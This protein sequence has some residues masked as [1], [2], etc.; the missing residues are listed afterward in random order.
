MADFSPQPVLAL[1]A[2]I[3][4]VLFPRLRYL[5]ALYLIVIGVR[6]LGGV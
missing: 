5:I 6:G 3:L 1:G 4:V 2:G